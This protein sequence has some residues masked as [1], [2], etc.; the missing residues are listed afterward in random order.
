MK[1]I[2]NE[3]KNFNHEKIKI[4]ELTI[5]LQTACQMIS[6]SSQKSTSNSEGKMEVLELNSENVK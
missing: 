5:M 6:C 2:T 3:I 1:K 4:E